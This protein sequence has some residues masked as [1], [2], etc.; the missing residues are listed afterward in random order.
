MISPP[1]QLALANARVDDSRRTAGSSPTR[2]RLPA[3]PAASRARVTLRFGSPADE[4]PLARLAELDSARPPAQPVLLAE[5]DG[6][7]RAAVALSDG[8]V[9]A[10]PFYR[11]A[12]LI[13]LLR[14]RVRQLDR[15]VPMKRSGRLRSWAQLRIPAWR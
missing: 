12:E 7:V 6:R 1:L 10:D 4:A 14:A 8:S 9:V 5:V 11:T 2:R 13:D 3:R 15:N